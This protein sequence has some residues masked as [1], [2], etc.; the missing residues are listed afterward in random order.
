MLHSNSTFPWQFLKRL[1]GMMIC[2]FFFMVFQFYGSMKKIVCSQYVAHL[3]SSTLYWPILFKLHQIIGYRWSEDL[4]MLTNFTF[5][6]VPEHGTWNLYWKVEINY[7]NKNTDV[8]KNPMSI[9]WK[10]IG[11]AVIWCIMMLIY[12]RL[13]SNGSE[14]R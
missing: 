8:K 3:L 11:I 10:H 2:I 5:F 6:F 7:D 13:L 1:P 9:F 12:S 4:F 14:K